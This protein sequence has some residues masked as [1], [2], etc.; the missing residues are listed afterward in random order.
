[1]LPLSQ[2]PTV[3]PKTIVIVDDSLDLIRTYQQVLELE[4]YRV[5]LAGGGLEALEL[6]GR[7]PPPDLLLVDC[8]MPGM[9]GIDFLHELKTRNEAV[10]K[11]TPIVGLTG[12]F[13]ESSILKEMRPLVRRLVEKPDTIDEIVKLVNETVRTESIVSDQDSGEAERRR[14]TPV[15]QTR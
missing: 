13:S 5:F 2:T 6:L 10:F 8:L 12:L 1:M 4:G 7:I 9:S 11:S 15:T 14:L 3:G